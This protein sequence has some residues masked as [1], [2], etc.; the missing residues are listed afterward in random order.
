MQIINS[1]HSLVKVDP[2][3]GDYFDLLEIAVFEK[4]A[5]LNWGTHIL[6]S[7]AI[8]TSALSVLIAIF[9]VFGNNVLKDELYYVIFEIS[10]TVVLIL[11]GISILIAF[12]YIKNNISVNNDLNKLLKIIEIY[13]RN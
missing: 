4:I 5:S 10:T 13:R 1:K 3:D 6:S 9:S 12:R 11:V 8:V 2:L 7:A